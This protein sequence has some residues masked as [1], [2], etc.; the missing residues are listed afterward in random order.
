MGRSNLRDHS[1]GPRAESTFTDTWN[2]PGSVDRDWNGDI[3]KWIHQCIHICYS[4]HRNRPERHE[5]EPEE[6]RRNDDRFRDLIKNPWFRV[7]DIKNMKLAELPVHAGY[8]EPYVALSYRWGATN[9]K[10]TKCNRSMRR[11]HNKSIVLEE[12]P[13]TIRDTIQLVS[14]LGLKRGNRT[15][16]YLWI[17]SLCI[18]QDEHDPQDWE[19]NAETMDLVFGNA[20][21][22]ICAADEHPKHGLRAIHDRRAPDEREIMPGLKLVVSR[23]SEI[24]LPSSEWN[25]R[26]WTFQEHL[27][28]RRC[29]IFAGNRIYFQCR[30]SNYD[31]TGIDWS[32]DWRKSALLTVDEV[33]RRPIQFYMKAVSLY[34][35]RNLTD[36]TDI[37]K[38]FG[39]VAG[40]IDWYTCAPLYSGLPSSH[41]DFA[42]LWRPKEG[43]G[44]RSGFPSWSWSGW[45]HDDDPSIGTSALYPA[46][47]LEGELTNL[48]RWLLDRTWI[49]WYIQS[50]NKK[51]PSQLWSGY[52]P[53]YPERAQR[54]EGRWRGYDGYG[55]DQREAFKDTY[56]R[57]RR[58]PTCPRTPFSPT[59][60]SNSS[61]VLRFYTW[62]CEFFIRHDT[63][64]CAPGD[65]LARFDV[66]D[67]REDWCGTVVVDENFAMAND[68]RLCTFLALSETRKF[69]DDE[70]PSWTYPIPKN[71]E[72]VEWDL[73][74]VM[75][76]EQVAEEARPVFE[77]RGLGKAL[78]MAFETGGQDWKEIALA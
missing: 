4:N 69:T 66:L 25:K 58:W 57:H 71:K 61:P 70:C 73:F 30:K 21:F 14:R 17:D 31:D 76:V 62:K 32:A 41:F 47:V 53:L 13:P 67:Q 8:P 10:T 44:R 52:R 59:I 35:G 26:G 5:D 72:D 27:L 78:K 29:L 56:G 36:P 18:V 42:M 34:T 23:S 55:P 3:D 12:M 38:A 45:Q 49:E 24:V 1:E 68:E 46:D 15:V 51:E 22:T 74:N 64:A 77:R 50:P 60:L 39:G 11:R 43:K 33:K 48:N 20:F 16:R 65:G 75:I 37:L 6:S 28:S 63:G 19:R 54:V 2:G 9:H 7:V 40:L